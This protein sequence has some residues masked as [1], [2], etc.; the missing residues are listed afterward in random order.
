S[1]PVQLDGNALYI[2]FPN[3]F[4]KDWVEARYANPVDHLAQS[5]A[6]RVSVTGFHPILGKFV[7]KFYIKG[8]TVKLD[9]PRV[10]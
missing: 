3:E 5:F 10:F 8:V 9:R 2:E 6:Q 4:T 1:R 7:G